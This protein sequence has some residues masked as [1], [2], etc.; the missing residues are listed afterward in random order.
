MELPDELSEHFTLAEMT[1]SSEAARLGIDNTPPESAIQNLIRVCATMEKV[2][3]LLGRQPI[4]VHSG[5]RSPK[6]NELV[7]G[8]ETSEHLLGLA[9]DFV[10]SGWSNLGAALKIRDSGIPFDQLILEYGWIHL[11]LAPEGK[12]LRQQCLTKRSADSPYEA[13]L[14]V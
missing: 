1:Q 9:V 6:V 12:P 4:F 10:V 7:G 11:G 13:G 8:A 3:I 14:Q 2:R 5:Y